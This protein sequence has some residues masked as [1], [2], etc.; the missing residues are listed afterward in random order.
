MRRYRAF[1]ALAVLAVLCLVLAGCKKTPK[2]DPTP[3]PGGAPPEEK[4]RPKPETK[5]PPPLPADDK[6]ASGNVQAAVMEVQTSLEVPGL[7]T[8]G[9]RTAEAQTL[10]VSDDRGKMVFNTADLYVPKGTE[11]RYNPAHKKYVLAD[12]GKKL[13]WA[14]T[15]SEIGNLLEGGPNTTRSSYSIEV[16]DVAGKDETIAGVKVKQSDAL[17]S[18]EW[19]V[20]MKNGK[21]TGKV[22]VKLSIWHSADPKLKEPW[23]KMMVDFLT[24]PF[25]SE[26]GQQVVETLKKTVKFPVKWSMEVVNQAKKDAKPFKLVTVAQ[27]LE[28]KDVPRADLASPPAGFKKS[29]EPYNEWGE[30]GQTVSEEELGKLPAK[31]GEPPTKTEPTKK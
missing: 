16:K 30:G 13:Y 1:A 28:V 27:K 19:A 20:D 23:G 6:Y 12:P 21:K 10:V 9:K 17:I 14:M 15:G 7:L 29:D 22:K 26:Q 11:L 5:A 25:Q 2:Q 8:G 24:V 18:F 3:R 4:A 31:K